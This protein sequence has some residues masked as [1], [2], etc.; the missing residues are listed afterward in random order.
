MEYDK[1]YCFRNMLRNTASVIG[2]A[3]LLQEYCFRNTASGILP[4]EYCLGNTASGILLQEYCFRNTASG[5][6]PLPET[7]KE[8]RTRRISLPKL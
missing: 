2:Q 6:Y 5:I 4:R 3:I 7:I 8:F 1:Q